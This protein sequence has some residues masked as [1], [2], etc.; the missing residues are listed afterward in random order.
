MLQ[1][2]LGRAGSGKTEY[3]RRMLADKALSG[4]SRCIMLVPEQYSF[5]TEKAM[6]RLAGARQANTIGIYS[7]TRL[8][9]T[10]FRREGGA[11]GRRLSDG[12]RRIL[13]SCAIAACQDSLEVYRSA[14]QSGRTTD[15]MLTAVNEMKMCGIEPLQLLETA[16]RLKGR[17]LGQ[18]VREL[19]LIFE[20]YEALVAAS[21]LDARDD[22]TRLAQALEESRFFA[23]CTVAVD[24]FE[25]FTVQEM[26]VLGQ[27]LRRAETVTVS[28]CT[29][30]LGDDA[31]LFALVDRT[32]ARLRRLAEEQGVGMLPPV[33]LTGAPR[34]HNE[35]LKL[36]EAG[37]FSGG[38]G[39]S[40]EDSQGVALFQ[41]KDVY[42]E[43]EFVAATVRRLVEERHWRYRDISIICRDPSRYYGSLD[44]ALKKRDIPCFMSQPMRVDAEPVTRFALGAFRCVQSGLAT[45]SLLELLKTGV[46]GFTAEEIS[47]L[48]NYA[49]LWKV[50]GSG[51]RQEFVRHPQGFGRE[52]TEA[53]REFLAYVNGLRQRLITPLQQFA[54]ATRDATGEEISQA[55]YTLLTAYGLEETLP[56]Y[57][58]ELERAGEEGLAARQVRVW[59]LLME[60]L[61]QMHSILGDRKISRERYFQLLREVLAAED[62]SEIPQTIDQVLFGTAEQVR[63]SS[64]KAAFLI[65][66]AQGEF[67]LA[68]HSSGVFSDAERRALLELNLPL[69]DPLE[70]KAIEERYLA[71]SVACAPSEA[72][73]ISWPASISGEDREPSELVAE[74]RALFPALAPLENLPEEYFANSLEA[75]FSYMAPRLQDKSPQAQAL[76]LLFA[77]DAYYE[78][79][80]AALERAAGQGAVG[81]E[82]PELAQKIYGEKPFVSPTQIETFHS[83]AFKYFCRYGINARERRP[84]E[85]DVM[86]YGTLMHYLFEQVFQCPKEQRE[87]WTQQELEQIVQGHIGDYARDSLG[88]MELLSGRQKYRLGR[89]AQSACKLI[90]H[91]EKELSQSRFAPEHFE[92]GLGSGGYPPLQV[93][94]GNGRTVTVGGTIDRV[95]VYHS[96]SGQD[97]VRVIDYKTG[98]KIFKLADVLYGLNMQML[99]YLAALVEQGGQAPA[100]ILYMPAAEPSV[101]AGRG[102]EDAAVQERAD[103]L[104]RMNGVVL[105]D[106]EIIE[107]MEAGAKGKFIPAALNKDGS[108]RKSP[109]PPL[110][111]EQ[112]ALVLAYSKKLIAAMGRELLRGAAE[113]R[114]NLNRHNACRLCPY[115]AVCGS[116]FSE[117]DVQEDDASQEEALARMRKALQEGGERDG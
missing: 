25:G 84:A 47:D 33:V 91:V 70:Q 48:E 14:A 62:V 108:L 57:C 86:Q 10:V 77:G 114:P 73:Y 103:K 96:P 66:V 69:G 116:E 24:S 104:L 85:V 110:T 34:F 115:G 43:S 55:V 56:A 98:R 49:F 7:F 76:R 44:V 35:S 11:A 99:V 61:D 106:T 95:D 41:A 38:E 111:K 58:R 1:F 60:L 53:D 113:A 22:L 88:G 107:A 40:A 94:L 64:P 18:K 3:M 80:I 67:P 39:L 79:R 42:Q 12:G 20:T 54:A 63:Q 109:S 101:S 72:L 81:M 97:Y 83:C 75:A 16:G 112:M 19:G 15:M 32:H 105:A 117:N 45:D 51:W 52:F 82:S 92:L 17:G 30:G 68:P 46:S 31:G 93:E 71:Y 6:L 100:G 74:V 37:L 65:G 4:D 13:M 90:R 29:D 2:V 27:I 102:E 59:E 87:A 89:M 5:E 28:L 26:K 78:G 23:G 9:E 8:A 21:Y 50:T 36:L